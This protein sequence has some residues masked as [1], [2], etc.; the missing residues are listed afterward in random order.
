MWRE[1]FGGIVFEGIFYFGGGE[2]LWLILS[3]VFKDE[4]FVRSL[5][6]DRVF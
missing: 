6:G 2:F 1:V 4:M 3:W 5:R